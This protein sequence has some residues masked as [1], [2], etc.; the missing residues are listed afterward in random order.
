MIPFLILSI[1]RGLPRCQ[2]PKLVTSAFTIDSS[3]SRRE[4]TWLDDLD[5]HRENKY[6][7]LSNVNMSVE[8]TEE[9]HVLAKIKGVKL[10]TGRNY[11]FYPVRNF[12][13]FV[14]ATS[15]FLPLQNGGKRAVHRIVR[16]RPLLEWF[17]LDNN[18]E[19]IGLNLIVSMEWTFPAVFETV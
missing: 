10:F 4:Q 14:L 5:R 18:D 19:T 6:R 15:H 12:T 16:N 1:Y 11:R 3:I 7:I 2:P 17:W 8:F 13:S 9:S